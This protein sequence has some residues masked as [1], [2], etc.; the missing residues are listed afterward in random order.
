MV[1]AFFHSSG[2]KVDTFMLTA[3]KANIRTVFFCKNDID[4]SYGIC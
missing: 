2:S 1:D 4:N 3:K